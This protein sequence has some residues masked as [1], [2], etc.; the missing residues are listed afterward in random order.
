MHF[1]YSKSQT[2]DLPLFSST[3][4]P[5]IPIFSLAFLKNSFKQVL[6]GRDSRRI[7]AYLSLN[8][9]F[10]FVEMGYGFWTNSLGLIS[11]AFHMLFDCTALAIVSYFAF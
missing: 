1:F 2:E 4:Q 6:E 11:D 3:Q 5:G 7:F 10:M 9:I 8:L